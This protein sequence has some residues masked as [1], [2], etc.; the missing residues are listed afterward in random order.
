ME[1]KYINIILLIFFYF[2][3]SDPQENDLIS[4]PVIE[5]PEHQTMWYSKY[6]LGKFHHNY[7]GQD[8]DKS[9]YVLVSERM[10]CE[11]FTTFFWIPYHHKLQHAFF[12]STPWHIKIQEI[13]DVYVLWHFDNNLIS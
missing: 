5:N 4:A 1:V 12:R 9:T 13:F 6:F 7:V 10:S 3:S 8:G 11:E 2:S